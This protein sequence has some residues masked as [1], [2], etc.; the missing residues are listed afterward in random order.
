MI[1]CAKFLT[2]VYALKW[3]Q[4]YAENFIKVSKCTQDIED[5]KLF[6]E[7]HTDRPSP[8]YLSAGS[9]DEDML[10][11]PILSSLN[12]KVKPTVRIL[13]TNSTPTIRIV[14]SEAI[15]QVHLSE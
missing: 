3:Q 15:Q 11:R 1:G 13:E 2:N 10:S 5:R 7:F 14:T 6:Q 8:N 9:L 4:I 12:L